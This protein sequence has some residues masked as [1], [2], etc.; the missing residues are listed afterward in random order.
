V[1]FQIAGAA[2]DPFDQRGPLMWFALCLLRLCAK[3]RKEMQ[4]PVCDRDLQ[5]SADTTTS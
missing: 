1:S 2:A 5:I 3:L 4:R